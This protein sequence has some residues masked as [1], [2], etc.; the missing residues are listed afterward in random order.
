MLGEEVAAV[1]PVCAGSQAT[2][3]DLQRHMMK[4]LAGFK[5]PVRIEL[6]GEPLPGNPNRK[7]LK[8]TLKEEIGA[9]SAF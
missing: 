5:V 2:R 8:A 3:E 1:V 7:I 4:H 6:R 9:G